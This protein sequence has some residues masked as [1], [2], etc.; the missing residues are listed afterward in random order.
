MNELTDGAPRLDRRFSK[1]GTG[2]RG[3]VAMMA[4]PIAKPFLTECNVPLGILIR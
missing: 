2:R 3:G 4:Y 1:E